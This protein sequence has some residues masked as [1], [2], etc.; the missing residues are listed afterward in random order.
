MAQSQWVTTHPSAQASNVW[1]CPV[2]ESMPARAHPMKALLSKSSLTPATS[3]MSHFSS[4]RADTAASTATSEEEHA[5]SYTALGPWK[6]KTYEMRPEAMD[7]VVPVALYT[8]VLSDL[9]V[10]SVDDDVDDDDA[11]QPTKTPQFN[12]FTLSSS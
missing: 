9:N 6:L 2:G 8:E 10:L 3:A 7:A 12:S 1:Q 11:V 4:V 5:V